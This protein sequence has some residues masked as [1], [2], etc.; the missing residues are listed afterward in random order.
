M[1]ISHKILRK[2]IAVLTILKNLELDENKPINEQFI[3][4][5]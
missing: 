3:Q 4:D 1:D 2:D 5:L